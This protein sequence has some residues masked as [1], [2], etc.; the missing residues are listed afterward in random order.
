MSALAGTWMFCTACAG[1][2]P[3]PV[4]K[5]ASRPVAERVDDLLNQ[6][7]LEEKIQLTS[8]IDTAFVRAVPRLGLPRIGTVDGPMGIHAEFG[9]GTC[10]PAAVCLA[11]SWDTHLAEKFGQ[12]QAESCRAVG[13]HILLGP[14]VNLAR[15]PQLGRTAEYMG[16]DPLLAGKMAA[17][18]VR[19][20][21]SK[22]VIA[23]IKHFA[24]N[25]LEYPRT[26]SDSVIDERTLRELYLRPFEIAVKEARVGSV[27]GA[28]NHLNGIRCCRSDFLLKQ[29]LRDE[30]GFDGF[31]MSDWGA[32]STLPQEFAMGGLDLAMPSGWM[33]DP[34]KI[35]PLI[36]KGRI[37]PSVYDDKVRHM[38]RKFI[39]FGFLDRPQKDGSFELAGG[40][41]ARIALQVA[42][43]GMV[44]LKN[45]GNLLPVNPETIRSI[46][47]IGPHAKKDNRDEPYVTGP[48]GSSSINPA[49]PVEILAAM[50]SEAPSGIRILEAS[51]PMENLYATTQYSHA[52]SGGEWVPGL[53]VRYYKTNDFSGEP[54]LERVEMDVNAHS[55][56][57]YKSW[58]PEMKKYIKKMSVRYEGFIVPGES[59]DYLFAKNSLPGCTVW[60][61]GK[62]I[63]DD[64]QEL[65][66]THRPIPSQSVILPLEKGR[67][68]A[69]KIEYRVHPDFEHWAGLRFG[70][71][72]A[73]FS[74]SEAVSAART[75]DMAVVCIGYDYLTEGEGFERCWDLPDRQAELIDAVA[76]VNSNVVVVL[77]GGG[78]CS[79]Q[80]WIGS[81]PALLHAW[82][83]GENGA[84]AVAEI[85]YGKVNPSGKLPVTFDRRLE[86]NPSTPYFYADWS[87]PS[88]YPVRYTEG[89]FMGYRGYDRSEKDPLFPFGHGLSYTAF[90]YS[91]LKITSL[92]DHSVEVVCQVGN[93]GQRAGAEVVQLYVGDG[94]APLPR[95]PRELKQF[96]R[97]ELQPGEEKTVS[98]T[99]NER[100]FA[101]YDVA[102]HQWTVAPGTFEIY[103]GGSSRD[104]RLHGECLIQK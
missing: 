87:K 14:A 76:A 2:K 67:R 90:G 70:W 72:P 39:E 99:L 19:G 75:A 62:V 16:E 1:A 46:A 68:Y 31:V 6:L 83:L 74:G 58:L 69:L 95:P 100:A 102:A 18:V 94:H 78:A 5:D 104:I 42:R 93:T 60:L 7:T 10:M 53:T 71:G 11:A 63:L 103:V 88:P 64:G 41:N 65:A 56:W 47:V 28:Y 24:G 50:R 92:P 45:E 57:R 84:T 66:L 77:T 13:R 59:A 12:I 40:G 44:L 79:S 91:N 21:Q 36:G 22:G 96:E 8:G 48:S 37:D 85:L 54:E 9:V 27:M 33:G 49:H 89:L 73:D 97:V 34:S 23:C 101:Y 51:D 35:L 81:V 17:G 4:Y 30:W 3:I 38:Y 29:V 82:Y 26:F 52:G 20:A 86:D 25:E 98:F 15:N 32:G 43:E 80:D 61:D 55:R